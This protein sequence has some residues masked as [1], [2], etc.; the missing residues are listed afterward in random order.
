[1]Q[2]R[3]LI[4][5]LLMQNIRSGRCRKGHC[6]WTCPGGRMERRRVPAYHLHLSFP[7]SC[8]FASSQR[9]LTP[10]WP[11]VTSGGRDQSQAP[12]PGPGSRSSAALS[13]AASPVTCCQPGPCLP[14]SAA[15]RMGEEFTHPAPARP[16][17]DQ[18]WCL[19]AARWGWGGD[20]RHPACSSTW[21]C[22]A[23]GCAL[24]GDA[25]HS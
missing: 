5:H 24:W 17:G 7:F 6:S 19:K 3:D 12:S 18:S 4:V 10:A 23:W 16:Q 13:P 2:D 22:K 1:M 11:W 9:A 15:I 25:Q 21:P 20:Q 8:S 14:G